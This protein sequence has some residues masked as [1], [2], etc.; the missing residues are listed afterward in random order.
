MMD[1]LNPEE[2]AV[3]LR[4]DP[5]QRVFSVDKCLNCLLPQEQHVQPGDYCPEWR[6]RQLDGDR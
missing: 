4:F 3:R 5:E 2:I 6:L 1:I